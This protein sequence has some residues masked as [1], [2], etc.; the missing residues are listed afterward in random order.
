M[1][2][3]ISSRGSLSGVH[4]SP[5]AAGKNLRGGAAF[6]P[7]P[8]CGERSE[9]AACNA[10]IPG[11]GAPEKQRG[12][13]IQRSD[14]PLMT[15]AALAETPPPPAPSARLS[16]PAGRGK[17]KNAPRGILFRAVPAGRR[18]TRPAH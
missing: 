6:L 2:A 9:S 18:F 5:R 4:L 3:V 17:K 7:R 8:A 11:E 13:N 12:I 15:G 14:S 16:P 1:F 10:R